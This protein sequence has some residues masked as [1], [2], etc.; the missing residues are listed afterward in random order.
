MYREIL[1]PV[2]F[3]VKSSLVAE[4]HVLTLTKKSEE[5]VKKFL[6]N[7]NEGRWKIISRDVVVDHSWKSSN[8]GAKGEHP[9][10]FIYLVE[11]RQDV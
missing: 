11:T 10:C 8:T 1:V 4:H 2:C 3:Q 6:E 7:A 9:G 5:I